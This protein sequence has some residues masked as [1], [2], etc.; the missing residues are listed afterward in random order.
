[1]ALLGFVYLWTG[2]KAKEEN[3]AKLLRSPVA[4]ALLP[5]ISLLAVPGASL[6]PAR[7]SMSGP[8]PGKTSRF[9]I[10]VD[11]P[12]PPERR[13]SAINIVT[14]PSFDGGLE[15]P[16]E[17][18]LYSTIQPKHECGSSP[19]TP[20]P[21]LPPKQLEVLYTKPIKVGSV[22]FIY[23]YL[24]STTYRFRITFNNLSWCNCQQ[25]ASLLQ[26]NY[27]MKHELLTYKD[28]IKSLTTKLKQFEGISEVMK[29]LQQSVESVSEEN[30]RLKQYEKCITEAKTTE[31]EKHD[32]FE[33]L[34][35]AQSQYKHDVDHLSQQVSQLEREKQ[36]LEGALAKLQQ[37]HDQLLISTQ[38][39]VSFQF[40]TTAM[41]EVKRLLE[42]LKQKYQNDK[43]NLTVKVQ[44]AEQERQ[45]LKQ[46]LVQLEEE[47]GWLRSD[48]S[49]LSGAY[50]RAVR[51]NHTLV[52]HLREL[53]DDDSEMH[54]L[55]SS[56]LVTA[57]QVVSERDS[58]EIKN[59]E[60]EKE[61]QR[62]L[63]LLGQHN[64][65]IDQL[66]KYLKSMQ[67]QTEDEKY[68]AKLRREVEGNLQEEY[69]QQISHLHTKVE[70]KQQELE[71]VHRE[72][73]FRQWRSSC[74]GNCGG[75][76]SVWTGAVCRCIGDSER[77]RREGDRDELEVRRFDDDMFEGAWE[78]IGCCGSVWS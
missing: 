78:G 75:Q 22:G 76:L 41:L 69:E 48:H 15:Q 74:L 63:E 53:Q 9:P 6:E 47:V 36:E 20:P 25:L 4:C 44:L 70:Q 58:L 34:K 18:A 45:E 35:D 30:K 38:N 57:H 77:R 33:Q 11:I 59:E 8:S 12:V 72:K 55:L 61:C 37:E 32:L 17:E 42:E 43:E 31:Q 1:M 52:T 29:E 60:K 39:S 5:A 67:D 66:N 19:G 62:M 40:H 3:Q 24:H 73:R 26:D 46:Q 49:A 64:V 51:Q 71:S 10:A 2:A 50:R 68:K 28:R 14:N 16:Q 65:D 23:V 54:S 13:T 7:P 27:A 56:L 21:P